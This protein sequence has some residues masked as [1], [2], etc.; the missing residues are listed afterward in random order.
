VIKIAHVI[1]SLGTG[2]A[3]TML[4]KLVSRLDRSA[5]RPEVVSLTQD[6]PVGQR[7]RDAGV[8]VTALGLRRNPTAA[9]GLASLRRLLA[10]RRPD[11]VQ[12]WLYHA[13]LLGGLA[14]RAGRGRGVVWTVHNS[15]LD[16]GIARRRTIWAAWLCARASRWLPDRIVCCSDAVRA[17]HV[18]RGYPAH[19]T[20]VIPNG[21]DLD[22][23]RPDAAAGPSLRRELGWPDGAVLIGMLARFD[24]LKDHRTFLEAARLLRARTAAVGF[25][26]CGDGVTPDNPELAK[27]IRAAGIEADCRLLGRRDDVARICAGLDVATLSSRSEGLPSVIGEAMAAGTPCVATAVGGT[28]SL[29][30]DTGGLVPPGDPPALAAAWEECVTAGPAE[31]R[32]R[33]AAAR[34]RIRE[35]FSLPAVVGRYEGLYRRLAATPG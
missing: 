20:E 21:F 27:W 29:V 15:S 13:D 35:H 10:E 32:R 6:G 17:V 25:V 18:D 33:G 5:F 24:P 26:L 23:F 3:E 9:T 16:P 14:A 34:Q 8:P 19:R 4:Y 2:G 30:G 7:I 31:R 22:A 12:T 28:A 11:L 1:T